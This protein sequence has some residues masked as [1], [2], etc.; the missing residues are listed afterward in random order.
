MSLFLSSA[1]KSLISFTSPTALHTNHAQPQ[2]QVLYQRLHTQLQ[3]WMMQN[4]NNNNNNIQ[5]FKCKCLSK[6]NTVTVHQVQV[7]V[8]VQVPSYLRIHTTTLAIL[9]DMLNSLVSS[10]PNSYSYSSLSSS[11]SLSS[12]FSSIW[13]IKRTY[14]PSIIRKRR[15]TGFLERQRT[16]GGRRTLKRRIAKGRS[17]LGGC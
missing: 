10:C 6:C 13:F 9:Q 3:H 15:K 14:Q 4:N 11:S 8:P 1:R 17:R 16:V 7:P 2:L 5:Q 12:I